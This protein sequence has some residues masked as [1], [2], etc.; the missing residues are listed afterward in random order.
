MMP[1]EH[2]SWAVL[3]AP[4]VLGL[5][6]AAPAPLGA[7]ACF[8]L[9]ALGAFLLRTPFLA[10]AAAPADRRARNWLTAYAALAA[11]PALPLFFFYRRWALLG[12]SL[13]VPFLLA[14]TW[15]CQ[16][17][18]KAMSFENEMIGIAGLALTAPAAAYAARGASRLGDWLLWLLCALY[19]FG[20][21][22]DVKLAAL[23][24]RRAAG[25]NV[26]AALGRMKRASLPY[27]VVSAAAAGVLAPYVGWLALAPFAASLIKTVRRAL[28]GPRKISFQTLGYTEV[29]YSLLFVLC[30]LG[31]R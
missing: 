1:K 3:L 27:H 26:E 11:L 25:A 20:P 22:F 29:G 8:A 18:R 19:F 24:H 9:S 17:A 10:L 13:P 28:S 21:V 31:A 4:L 23:L 12:F 15:R 14:E 16:R 7:A 5:A 6:W 30:L 2:G